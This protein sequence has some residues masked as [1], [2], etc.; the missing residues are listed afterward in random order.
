[1]SRRV[2]LGWSCVVWLGLASMASADARPAAPPAAAPEAAAVADAGVAAGSSEED[3]KLAALEHSLAFRSGEIALGDGLAKLSLG[4]RLRYL[5]PEDTEKVLAAWGNPPGG[6]TLGMLF[7]TAMSPFADDGWGV[8]VT[9]DEEGHIDDDDAEELD[10][11]EMLESMKKDSEESNEERKQ[12]GFAPVHL[13]GWAEPPH[14]DKAT[15]KLY[16]AKELD[17]GNDEHTLNYAVR[18]LGRKGVLQLNAVASMSALPLIRG[19]MEATIGRLN[20]QDGHRYIDFDPKLDKVAAYGIGAL[21]AGKVAAKAGL[22]KGLIPLL[23]AS[24]K[25]VV[26]GAVAVLAMLRKIFGRGGAQG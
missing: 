9:Y 10:Y 8:V 17:F 23:V 22:L 4:D 19:E 20:F 13:I 18:V 5:G 26:A 11:A 15:K 25:L 24:K 1:M 6:E 21:I 2:Q 14:Y 12:A 7:P 16:W 3:R